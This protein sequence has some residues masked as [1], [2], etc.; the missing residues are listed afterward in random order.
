MPVNQMNTDRLENVNF[1]RMREYR[2]QR[3]REYMEKFNIGTLITWDAYNIRYISGVYVTVPT[4]WQE[5]QF[6][7]LPRNDDPYVFCVTSFSPEAMEK[8]IPWLKGRIKVRPAGAGRQAFSPDALENFVNEIGKIIDEHGL[9]DELVGLDGCS[10]ELFYQEAFARKGFKVCDAQEAMFRAR[11]VKSRDEINCVEIACAMAEAAFAEI[12]KAIKPGVR[13]CELVGVGMK[14]L[15]ELGADECQEFVCSSG[16]RTNPLHID[17]TDRIIRNGDL[18]AVDINGNS[19][20]TYKSCYY[21]TFVCGKASEEQKKSFEICKKILYSAMDNIKAGVS[22]KDVAEGWPKSPEF[23]GYDKDDWGRVSGFALAHGCGLS[24]HEFPNFRPQSVLTT[25]YTLEEGMVLAVETW[26][27]PKGG[28]HGV[29]L[30]EMIEVTKDGYRL[31]TKAP[32]DGLIECE[33]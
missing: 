17:Y 14:K 11:S 24:L 15:Y 10:T 4:R 23:W 30:E 2:L 22:T 5:T 19:Y 13:E 32:I 18:I 16:P 8:E 26:Y 20:N 27:G 1:A 6:V 9:H 12:K 3:A 33:W 7:V 25:N 29:R 31:L 21:R 28:D